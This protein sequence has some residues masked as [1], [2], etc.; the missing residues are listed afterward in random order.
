MCM[1]FMFYFVRILFVR[2]MVSGTHTFEGD[3]KEK[4]KNITCKQTK[5]HSRNQQLEYENTFV[6]VVAMQTEIKNQKS[7]ARAHHSDLIVYSIVAD[8][9]MAHTHTHTNLMQFEKSAKD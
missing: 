6:S 8:T 7:K 3:D 4:F 9:H 1:C 5:N 2:S